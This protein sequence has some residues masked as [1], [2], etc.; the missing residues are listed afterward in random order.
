MLAEGWGE[1]NAW[2]PDM[3]TDQMHAPPIHATTGTHDGSNL[4]IGLNATP[5]ELVFRLPLFGCQY[6]GDVGLPLCAIP[7]QRLY[8]RL[9][10]ADKSKLVESTAITFALLDDD[11]AIPL[12]GQLPIYEICPNPWGARR[13]KVDGVLVDD[14]TKSGTDMGQPYLYGSYTVLHLEEEA[15]SALRSRP[16][17]VLFR[18]QRRDDWTIPASLWHPGS[19]LR[20]RLEIHGF[21]QALFFGIISSARRLQNKYRQITPPGN[22]EWLTNMALDVNGTERIQYWPPKKFRDLA[23]NTQLHRDV[24]VALYNLI[25]GVNP[26]EEPAGPCN[27]SRTQKVQLLMDAAIVLSDPATPDRT[28]FA[29]LFGMSWNVLDIR[30]GTCTVRFPD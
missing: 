25:F 27:L 6:Q 13:I 20:H 7:G 14:V 4:K 18:Q 9:W 29:F 24:P 10:L 16:L 12:L 3:E 26:E 2:Y 1:F 19:A 22:G 23:Q 28:A 11:D 21:F 17:E 8:L 30:D 15:R 5:P